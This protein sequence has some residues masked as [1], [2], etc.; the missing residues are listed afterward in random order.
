[1]DNT[2]K[3]LMLITAGFPFGESEQSF[4]KT[5]F[6][7]LCQT[8]HV[9]VLAMN[10]TEPMIHPFT[11]NAT[12]TRY[13]LPPL[14]SIKT[15]KYVFRLLN[16]DVFYEYRL[17]KENCSFRTWI[18]RIISISAEYI[19]SIAAS[20]KINEIIQQDSIDIVYTYWCT[21]MTIGSILLKKKYSNLKVITRF[22]GVDLYNERTSA[23]WQ[24]FRRLIREK[25]DKLI[26]AWEAAKNILY[27]I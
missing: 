18:K 21:S 5:E 17:A 1:M 9:N 15:L 26:F 25:S 11:E 14:K 2:K 4:L 27:L 12:V 23:N 7:T 24:P 6:T 10:T 13:S 16:K 19:N 22:H 20:K 8:F 3:K